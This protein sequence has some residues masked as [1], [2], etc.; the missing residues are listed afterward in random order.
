MSANITK[1]L[2][3]FCLLS[4]TGA[5]GAEGPCVLPGRGHFQIH[6]GTAGVFGAFAHNHL[7]EAQKVTG[8]VTLDSKEIT[9]SSIKL[10]FATDAI[11]VID[12]K[13]DAKDRAQVQKTM[14]TDVL[15][16]SQFPKVTFESTSIERQ[17]NEKLL[18]HG[19][20]TIR[21]TTRPIVVPVTFASQSDGTYRAFGENKLKQ[22]SFGIEPIRI[23][24]GTVKVKDELQVEFELFFR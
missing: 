2:I 6:V 4:A 7:V 19:N 8:C 1:L 3:A 11:R 14:E 23:A 5:S 18:V 10:E 12:P 21:G 22:S 15:R 13:E 9:N 24:G 17:T 16:I 20:L